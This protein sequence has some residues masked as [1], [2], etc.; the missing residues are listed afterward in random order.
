MPAP[1][2]HGAGGTLL[3]AE[4]K[5]RQ[6]DA[7]SRGIEGGRGHKKPE[8]LVPNS[9]QGFP[10]TPS[11]QIKGS[12]RDIAAKALGVSGYVVGRAAQVRKASPEEHERVKRGESTPQCRESRLSSR[13]EH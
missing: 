4:A 13:C 1:A 6:R 8:T 9:T 5:V 10:A 3:Q 12:A 2:A 11:N 7:G